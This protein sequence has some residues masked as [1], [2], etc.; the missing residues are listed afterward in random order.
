[1]WH[2]Y[3]LGMNPLNPNPNPRRVHVLIL[4]RALADPGNHSR[5]TVPPIINFGL[6]N[7]EVAEYGEHPAEAMPSCPGVIEISGKVAITATARWSSRHR[8]Y[9]ALG[10]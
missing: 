2:V 1:M 6:L 4:G 10:G 9:P 7:A 8:R 3:G 5:A